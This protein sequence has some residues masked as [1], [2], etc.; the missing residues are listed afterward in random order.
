VS[1]TQPAVAVALP[2]RCVVRV[3]RHPLAVHHERFVHGVGGDRGVVA[4]QP[5]LRRLSPVT[6][7]V[8][9]P[10]IADTAPDQLRS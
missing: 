6:F 1:R 9:A 7:S 8:T 4:D 5:R 3:K 10:P 2:Q